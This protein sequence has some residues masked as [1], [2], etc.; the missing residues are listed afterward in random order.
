M[1]SSVAK[2]L[3]FTSDPLSSDLE[4]TGLT[5]MVLYA[6]SDQPDTDFFIRVSDQKPTST[7]Q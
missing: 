2:I 5:E 6:S 4:I 7:I 1:P 3:T